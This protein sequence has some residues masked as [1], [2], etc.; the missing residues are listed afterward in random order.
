VGRRARA[1][2]RRAVRPTRRDDVAWLRRDP[3]R[4]SGIAGY[5]T[6]ANGVSCEIIGG[7]ATINLPP[8]GTPSSL[9]G[10]L[11]DPAG[12]TFKL[13][14]DRTD[15]TRLVLTGPFVV[16]VDSLILIC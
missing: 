7:S 8:P 12:G 14:C 5:H 11:P 2:A 3:V 15:G 13:E 6:D 4:G 1:G 9:D 16:P 10:G